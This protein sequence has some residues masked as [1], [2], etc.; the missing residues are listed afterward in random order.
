MQAEAEAEAE[1]DWRT[2]K[3]V[4]ERRRG[5]SGEAMEEGQRWEISEKGKGKTGISVLFR[6]CVVAVVEFDRNEK[7]KAVCSLV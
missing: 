7:K 2:E 6:W 3:A 4:M 5:R 1:V